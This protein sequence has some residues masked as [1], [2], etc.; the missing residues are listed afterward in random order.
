MSVKSKIRR[1][2]KEIKRL[3]NELETERLS[4]IRLH[5]KIEEERITNALYTDELENLTKY[6]ITKS[7]GSKKIIVEKYEIKKVENL[8]LKFEYEPRSDSL[9]IGV[10][11]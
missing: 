7:A 6:L 11:E 8:N 3:R 4:N 2:N 1:C 9:I 5:R 10:R